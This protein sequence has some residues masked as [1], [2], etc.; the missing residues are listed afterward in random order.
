MPNPARLVA[1]VSLDLLARSVA[2]L[3][4]GARNSLARRF[5]QDRYNPRVQALAGFFESALHGWKNRQYDVAVNG[6][7]ALLRRLAPFAPKVLFD[8]GANIGD[9]TLPALANIPGATI[10][11]FEIADSTADEFARNIAPHAAR[12]VLNRI[13]LAD[14]AGEIMLYIAPDTHTASS[15]LREAIH[16]SMATFGDTERPIEAVPARVTTGDLYMRERGIEH[17]DLLKIDVEGAEPAVLAGFA[18][19]FG[20]GAISMVQFEYGQLSLLT[21]YLLADSARFFEERGFALG[22]LLPEGVAFKPFAIDDEDFI[23]PNYVACHRSRGDIIEAL[24]CAP[25]TTG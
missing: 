6:E 5:M 18:E 20:R 16:A 10:H 19:A 15:T 9:W 23:G 24:R 1:S 11:A 25:L 21:R 8:V 22:K 14:H 3:P 2:L 13:G 12:V 17:I 4:A 7:A